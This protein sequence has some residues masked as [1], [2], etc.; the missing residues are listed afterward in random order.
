MSKKKAMHWRLHNAQMEEYRKDID[1]LRAV[2]VLA[3]VFFHAFPWWMPGG[4][5]GVDIFFVISGYLISAIIFR[6]LNQRKF[7][8][9]DFYERR[10][11]RLFPALIVVLW[12]VLALGWLS[13][14]D[15]EYKQLGRYAVAGALFF[16]NLLSWGEAGYFDANAYEK[17]LLHLWSLGVEEQFYLIWPL[18]LVFFFR[19][20]HKLLILVSVVA[21]LSFMVNVLTLGNFPDAA[22]YSPFSRFFELMAGAAIAWFGS[23]SQLT[24]CSSEGDVRN[25]SVMDNLYSTGGVLA[26]AAGLILINAS[27]KFPGFW[28]L[29]PTIGAALLIQA[30]PL[31]WIN[32]YILSWRPLVW[33]GLISY[34]LYLWHWPLLS[35]ARIIE[36]GTPSREVRFLCVLVAIILAYATFIFVEL[37]IRTRRYL[38]ATETNSRQVRSLTIAMVLTGIIG[39]A[40]YFSGGFPER[41]PILADI[42]VALVKSAHE[43][44]TKATFTACDAHLPS[45]IRCLPATLQESEKL[46]VIGD[47]HGDA[48]ADG[49]Y[50]ATQEVNLSV[51]VV[52][53][54]KLGC[55]PLRGV[56]SYSR[57]GI[58]QKCRDQYE[59]TY[60]CAID[61]PQVKTV[62]LVSRWARRVGEGLGFGAADGKLS[63]G[64]YGYM[65]DGVNIEDNSN[66][67]THA[68]RRSILDLTA[69][70]KRVIFIHQVP[71][72]GYYPPFCGRRPFPLSSLSKINDRCFIS[73]STVNRRQLEY[74]Q[75]FY[76]VRVEFPTL[77]TIDPLFTFCDDL[78][79]SLKNNY[80]YL[81]KDDDHLNQAGAYLFS[82]AIVNQLY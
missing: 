4:F 52:S 16:S 36:G 59:S 51:S 45:H 80:D 53:M 23:Y 37:P 73:R 81:Y 7:S 82:K 70:G 18:A 50:Q 54:F 46:L 67:F 5:I 13:L 25:S 6:A 42:D 41:V 21:L 3:V 2:A 71:E 77:I 47:S 58:S 22:F 11:I 19:H 48:L 12:A 35:F 27:R 28:V 20:S 29:L 64:H 65:N 32:R 56:E 63:S 14:L 44:A 55:H 75:L 33:V 79:C 17:P 8:L 66:I 60:R 76:P 61:D 9:L 31:A 39:G 49:L 62:L 57:F 78:R 34:P 1:G 15:F 30:G 10:L 68:L 40:I 43:N 69:A 24:G 26:I 72:F 74:R 38:D